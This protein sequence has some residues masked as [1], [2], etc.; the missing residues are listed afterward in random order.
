MVAAIS[1]YYSVLWSIDPAAVGGSLPD[2]GIYY[3]N[4]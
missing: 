4:N 1:D 3:V 2:D